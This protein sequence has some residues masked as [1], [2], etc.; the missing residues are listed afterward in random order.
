MKGAPM[1]NK[2]VGDVA[3]FGKYGLLRYLTGM[4]AGDGLERFPLG[5]VWYLQPDDI[6]SGAGKHINYLFPEKDEEKAAS[7]DC[8]PELWDKL[9]ALVENADDLRRCVHCVQKVGI[10]P[11]DTEFFDWQLVYP[12]YHSKKDDIRPQM[13][14]LWLR[15]AKRATSAAKLVYFD[16]DTSIGKDGEE[17]Q[18][19]GPEHAYMNDFKEFWELGRSLVIYHHLGREGKKP[20]AARKKANDLGRALKSPE[21]IPLLLKRGGG[22][23]FFVVPQ[24]EHKDTI[25]SR[26]DRFMAGLW[27]T[28]KHFRRV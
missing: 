11:K 24:P 5:V 22:P 9:R 19:T 6:H 23:V 15:E 17:C 26:V 10:L 12:P 25:E 27:G 3:D 4:T 1:Q 2:F 20:D 13:R 8:D 18:K 21:P 16:P 7:R 14:K 28:N